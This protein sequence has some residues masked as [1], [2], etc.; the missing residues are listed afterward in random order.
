MTLTEIDKVLAR[1][2]DSDVQF[3]MLLSTAFMPSLDIN[4]WY[5][6]GSQEVW[7]TVCLT[8][9]RESDLSDPVSIF[10]DLSIGY[11][12]GGDAF[13][14]V[15]TPDKG[16]L[17]PP[18]DEYVWSCPHCRGWIPDPQA[19]RYVTQNPGADPLIR[20]LL[21]PRTIS[22]KITPRMMLNDW[23]HAKTGDQKQSFFNRQ[24]A[25]PFIDPSQLPVTI[26]H[27]EDAAAEGKRVGL[28]WETK[29]Q[30][31]VPYYMGIDQMGGWCAIVIKKRLPDG[32]QGVVHV[33]AH[34]SGD[35]FA[36]CTELMHDFNVSVC[37]LEQLPNANDAR[38]FAN[39]RHPSG[40]GKRDH[41]GRVFLNTSFNSSPSAD[42]VS[43]GDLLSRSDRRTSE[44]DR[45]RCS[46]AISQYKAM[47]S[48]LYRVRN[49]QC[50]FPSDTFDQDVIENKKTR[51]INVVRDWVWNHFT[52][53]ALVIDL[54]KPEERERKPKAKVH[55]IEID[56]HFSFAAMLCEVAW[57][58]EQGMGI[59]LMPDEGAPDELKTETAK[60][61]AAAMPGLAKEVL[62]IMD[63]T[64]PG[65]CGRCSAFP[66]D[67]EGAFRECATRAPMTVRG[68]DAACPLFSARRG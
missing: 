2:G 8:C 16:L 20:S 47:Q 57:V 18:R 41:V 26:K 25:R 21:L 10:P 34:F 28:R 35:P 66:L 17:V 39:L 27:C 42:M 59:V 53:T 40:S 62:A 44:E 6:R 65:T 15:L 7:H 9:E 56:P 32:R 61:L 43:W 11:N 38:R 3:A 46:V 23:N 54:G 4:F 19:G 49:L 12:L 58:R 67:G 55:K 45:E 36:R 31:G 64:P 30:K 51:R 60:K 22:P 48:A 24:L 13:K 37:V 68:R 33:E 1:M 63:E 14:P 29:A 5:Q 52:K 50:L